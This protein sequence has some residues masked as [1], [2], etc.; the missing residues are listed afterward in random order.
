MVEKIYSIYQQRILSHGYSGRIT[1]RAHYYRFSCHLRKG[2]VL[3][4]L[5]AA[6]VLRASITSSRFLIFHSINTQK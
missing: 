4:A 1:T 6:A 2:W 5:L 3:G